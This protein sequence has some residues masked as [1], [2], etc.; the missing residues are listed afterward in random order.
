MT[1]HNNALIHKSIG[2]K[3]HISSYSILVSCNGAVKRTV[4][5]KAFKKPKRQ[6][7]KVFIHCSATDS[8]KHDNIQIIT[9]WHL[10]RGFNGIGYHFFIDKKG[11]LH[12][13]RSLENIPASQKGHNTGSIAIC[14]SGLND[15]TKASL[16]TLKA[17]CEAINISYNNNITFHGHCEVSNKSCPVFD[18]KS[19][20]KLDK[21]GKAKL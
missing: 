13:G 5:L 11:V 4:S 1:F 3:L 10:E 6:V 20:L 14:V 9:Q 17:L 16:S 12:K 21:N 7:S 8:L 18:Y 15:F 2:E 19:I